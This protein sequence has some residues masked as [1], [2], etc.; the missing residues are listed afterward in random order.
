MYLFE[1]HQY[2]KFEVID[3]D[4]SSS[5]D[6]IGSVESSVGYIAG[7]KDFTF[8]ADLTKG[9]AHNR[10]KIIARLVPVQESNWEVRMKIIARGVT[11]HTSCFCM[12]ISQPT[13]EILKPV[14]TSTG[15]IYVTAYNNQQ[16]SVMGENANFNPVSVK[17]S[18]IC[19]SDFNAKLQFKIGNLVEGIVIPVGT[20][21]S[22][23]MEI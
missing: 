9:G 6:V 7:A 13:I 21:Y 19:N 15:S 4:D 18:Q 14:I 16:S 17:A 5:Y 23:L 2:L 3:Q 10:G 8:E 1:Q 12:A 20:F 22:T 11:P